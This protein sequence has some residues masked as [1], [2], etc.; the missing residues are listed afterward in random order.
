M[1]RQLFC[2]TRANYCSDH[3]IRIWIKTKLIFPRVW[4][5]ITESLVEW[6]SYVTPCSHD[7]W[8]TVR[9]DGS[10]LF[11]K[12]L[13]S[14]AEDVLLRLVAGE[15]RGVKIENTVKPNI[16]RCIEKYI[17]DGQMKGHRSKYHLHRINLS[18]FPLDSFYEQLF[19]TYRAIVVHIWNV[20]AKQFALQWYH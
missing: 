3:L 14:G 9:C 5:T 1:P 7:G 17:I 16:L 13:P 6:A 19:Q 11:N 18:Q 8:P 10:C 20:I 12:T 15:H 4:N 2:F